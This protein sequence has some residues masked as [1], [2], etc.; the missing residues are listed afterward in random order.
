MTALQ[1]EVAMAVA[2]TSHF[3]C[4]HGAEYI[5]EGNTV[6]GYWSTKTPYGWPLS[7]CCRSS[8]DEREDPEFSNAR[9]LMIE[10]DEVP[11]PLATRCAKCNRPA[12]P[13]PTEPRCRGCGCPFAAC[14]CL[15]VLTE[16]EVQERWR[17]KS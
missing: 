4:P 13:T 14:K 10:V 9:Q 17:P 11:D 2:S 16:A 5:A 7:S 3:I 8:I 6:I 12:Y 15:N 1:S